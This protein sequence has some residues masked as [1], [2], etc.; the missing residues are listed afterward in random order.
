MAEF[1]PSIERE[2]PPQGT[3]YS[4]G[5][6]RND[7]FKDLFT[8]FAG[9]ADAAIKGTDAVIQGN[10]EKDVRAQV[11]DVQDLFGVS[12]ATPD[13]PTEPLPP[14]LSRG[15]DTLN[16]LSKGYQA[17]TVKE[18]HYYGKLNAIVKGLRAQYPGYEKQID[19]FIKET[20][21]IDPANSLISSIRKEA[22]AAKSASDSREGQ[23]L[24]WE[25]RFGG[26]IEAV[27][28]GYFNRPPD[29]RWTQSIIAKVHHFQA[30]KEIYAARAAEMNDKQL[31]GALTKDE[32][33]AE[34][35]S[36]AQDIGTGVVQSSFNSVYND[37]AQP[38][39]SIN[40]LQTQIR[41]LTVNGK[42][43]SP[44]MAQN[45][46]LQAN[47]IKANVTQNTIA[48]I[49]SLPGSEKMSEAERQSTISTAL[50]PIN[51]IVDSLTNE[52]YGLLG[53]TADFVEATQTQAS[54]NIL[55]QG[56]DVMA[57]LAAVSKIYGPEAQAILLSSNPDIMDAFS[58]SISTLVTA[59]SVI[60]NNPDVNGDQR[61][62]QSIS[63]LDAKTPSGI[64]KNSLNIISN[65]N[66]PEELRLSQAKYI[67]ESGG[68]FALRNFPVSE[69][70]KIYDT[71]I[72]PSTTRSIAILREKDPQIWESYR[73]WAYSNFEPAHKEEIDNARIK[74]RESDYI[75]TRLDPETLRFKAEIKDT[76]QRK[77]ALSLGV[78]PA[79]GIQNQ[80]QGKYD[81]LNL[82]LK[83]M[84]ILLE[85][86]GAM[87]DP[88]DKETRVYNAL[89]FMFQN[90]GFKIQTDAEAKAEKEK[91]KPQE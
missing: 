37:P 28:S 6:G 85:Q 10:I 1:N 26:I 84:K 63:G 33:I 38:V 89:T 40:D 77:S 4:R 5:I 59:N 82:A 3:S 32:T 9:V 34:A 72:S 73:R 66:A 67:F 18:S 36:Q 80:M 25:S 27:D 65:E 8:G 47:A 91:S 78:D 70:P 50:G 55:K 21:G 53:R 42:P 71:M 81:R 56:G 45:L 24:S 87:D 23:Q 7:T 15:Q 51:T 16:R 35:N 61:W 57:G 39:N 62:M 76:P 46:L 64:I 75:E 44:E 86:D 88:Q 2:A 20:T 29:Q 13:N 54:A 31:M 74:G 22:E 11:E 41:N 60:R 48:M 30:K 17:G 58:R 19:G 83:N 69:W 49:N 68:G 90:K 12:A 79:K 43:P 52:N 14:G